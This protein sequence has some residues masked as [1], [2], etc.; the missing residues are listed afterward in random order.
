[1]EVSVADRGAI[2]AFLID[3]RECRIDVRADIV[4]ESV[5]GEASKM[6]NPGMTERNVGFRSNMEKKFSFN[7]F[8]FQK[9]DLLI[10]DQSK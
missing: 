6:L 5:V 10:E 7:T 2:P 8:Q 3:I 4:A 1:V 9:S